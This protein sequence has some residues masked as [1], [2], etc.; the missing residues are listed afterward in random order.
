MRVG[1]GDFIYEYIP[2]WGILPP[3]Y[4]FGGVPDGAVDAQGRVYVFSR[5]DHPVMVFDAEGNSYMG[6]LTGDS[7]SGTKPRYYPCIH[8][9]IRVR[10]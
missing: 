9:F 1:S 3:G 4:E 6:E 8:K 10:Q 2:N 7:Q 5:S